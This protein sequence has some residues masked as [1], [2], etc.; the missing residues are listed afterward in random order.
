MSASQAFQTADN[1]LSTGIIIAIVVPCAI[2]GIAILIC[3]II[4]IYCVCCRKSKTSPGMVLQPQ[5]PQPGGYNNQFGGYNNQLGGYN[6]QPGGYNNQSA[7][8]A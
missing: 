1:A 7:F 8:M 5:A 3:L 2:V 6:N 4:C